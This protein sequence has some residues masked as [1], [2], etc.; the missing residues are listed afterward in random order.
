[1]LGRVR[2]SVAVVPCGPLAINHTLVH[3]R[4]FR[5]VNIKL[6]LAAP[7]QRGPTIF[8]KNRALEGLST[9]WDIALNCR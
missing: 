4:Y 6:K 8:I 1:M 9:L 5:F 7:A 3:L 2:R